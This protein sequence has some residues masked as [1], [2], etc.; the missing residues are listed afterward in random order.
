MTILASTSARE[1]CEVLRS[2]SAPLR[3]CSHSM[4]GHPEEME[5]Q[6]APMHLSAR[7]SPQCHTCTC[8]KVTVSSTTRGKHKTLTDLWMAGRFCL[9]MLLRRRKRPCHVGEVLCVKLGRLPLRCLH[10]H[11][12]EILVW[13]L[14]RC[15]C[16]CH[17]REAPLAHRSAA[18]SNAAGSLSSGWLAPR[19]K[20]PC[21]VG[22][23][24]DSSVV[25]AGL[26]ICCCRCGNPCRTTA[27]LTAGSPCN[28]GPYRA[29]NDH[30][31]P[32][33][34]LPTDDL[35][36]A[37]LR[38]RNRQGNSPYCS[39]GCFGHAPLLLKYYRPETQT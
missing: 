1:H 22:D 7:Q 14:P 20:C 18:I 5:L 9:Q 28:S 19:C 23:L 35:L 24:A 32:V 36:V 25:I 38:H 2:S 4:S 16:P 11:H 33:E 34:H 17:V 30:S 15:Q 6:E 3:V 12:K 10:L 29:G 37:P 13:L 21:G 8:W 26:Q 27:R 31:D 39:V